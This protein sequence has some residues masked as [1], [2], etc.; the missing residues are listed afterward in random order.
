MGEWMDAWRRNGEWEKSCWAGNQGLLPAETVYYTASWQRIW[1]RVWAGAGSV[2]CFWVWIRQRDAS[3]HSTRLHC[4][5]SNLQVFACCQEKLERCTDC[6]AGLTGSQGSDGKSSMTN[7]PRRTTGQKR[8]LGQLQRTS[9]RPPFRLEY[10]QTLCSQACPEI[11]SAP[12]ASSGCWHYSLS[13]MWPCLNQAN[14]YHL[15]INLWKNYPS[16]Y[17]W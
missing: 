14:C 4:G 16:K 1:V 17:E 5:S 15:L 13:R 3:A 9:Q 11:C 6:V 7:V 2:S 8:C 12:T 10:L